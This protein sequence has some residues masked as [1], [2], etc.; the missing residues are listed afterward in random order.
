M[1]WVFGHRETLKTCYR[2][3]WGQ[4]THLHCSVVCV[5]L[6]TWC[7]LLSFDC[8][9]LVSLQSVWCPMNG[10]YFLRK[11]ILSVIMQM[12]SLC[13][14]GIVLRT[15]MYWLDHELQLTWCQN[16]IHVM[17]DLCELITHIATYCK[18]RSWLSLVILVLSYICS[19][20]STY[21]SLSSVMPVWVPIWTGI[22]WL[23]GGW[24]QRLNAVSA[25]SF[26]ICW[27]LGLCDMLKAFSYADYGMS[28]FTCLVQ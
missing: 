27:V 3:V 4:Y 9:V 10:I 5:T 20:G 22:P 2:D 16:M 23:Y 18:V 12:W 17:L 28:M 13:W 24:C 11:G 25:C 19:L 1:C 14:S 7:Y 26:C 15:Y 21:A 8:S 6:V